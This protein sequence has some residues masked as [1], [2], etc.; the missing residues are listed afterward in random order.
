MFVGKKS[1]ALSDTFYS[2]H[3]E[4]IRDIG[5]REGFVAANAIDSHIVN[6]SHNNMG[7]LHVIE[8]PESR[9]LLALRHSLYTGLEQSAKTLTDDEKA[10]FLYPEVIIP[11]NKSLIE[12]LGVILRTFWDRT[13]PESFN[14]TNFPASV[15]RITEGS[16]ATS[17][18]DSI[19]VAF[20]SISKDPSPQA[21]VSFTA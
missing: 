21:K 18:A 3:F 5:F 4:S 1:E 16:I 13:T 15:A 12:C 19:A 6:S 17:M 2:V 11:I 9:Q 10:Q 7:P 8:D 14:P 20:P